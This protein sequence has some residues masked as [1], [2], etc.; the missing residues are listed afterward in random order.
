M[1]E[2]PG[3]PSFPHLSRPLEARSQLSHCCPMPARCS[4][5]LSHP[6]TGARFLA[7]A[8]PC[9]GGTPTLHMG[10]FLRLPQCSWKPDL[11]QGCLEG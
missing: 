11:V 3:R 2:L 8:Y 1:G 4:L 9:L 7:L 5:P 10:L 6:F